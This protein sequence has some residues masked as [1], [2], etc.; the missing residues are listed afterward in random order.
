MIAGAVPLGHWPTPFEAAPRLSALL[1]REIWLKREDLAATAL[2]GNKIRQLEW[3]LGA[4]EAAGADTVLTSAAAQSN[5]CRALAGAAAKRGL[6]CRLLLRGS[7]GPAQGNLLLDCVFGAEI[8]FVAAADPWHPALAAALEETAA[9]LRAAGRRPFVIHLPGASAPL[10]ALA[11]SAAAAELDADWRRAGIAPAAVVVAAG[12]GLTA[13]GLALGLARLDRRCQVRAVSVQ[14][15]AARLRSWLQTVAQAAA[16]R[17]GWPL[18]PL[19]LVV[20]DGWI[21]PGYGRPSRAALAAL[22]TVARCEGVVLDPVYTGKAMAGLIAALRNGDLPAG[23]VV[24]LHSGGLPGLF[25]AGE[26]VAAAAAGGS[27]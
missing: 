8:R 4:A 19:E 24:F 12:S 18:P 14:Q 1:G 16:E 3:L 20:D 23:P 22:L 21:G 25:A 15:P 11:W 5:F 7:D 10:A 13:L 26:A 27:A 9:E 17:A 6:A 2:G